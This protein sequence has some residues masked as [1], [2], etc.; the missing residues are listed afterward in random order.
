M[1]SAF[2]AELT[3]ARKR[4]AIW[5]LFATWLVLF[6]VFSFA[7]PY[8]GYLTE[9]GGTAASLVG[10]QET[11]PDQLVVNG[12]SGV[13]IF[14]GAILL[15][16][17]ALMVGSEYGWGTL[18]T[19]LTQRPTRLTV[20]WAK[21][22]A[23]V[24]AALGVILVT[25]ALGAALSAVIASIE[26]QPSSWPGLGDVL[27]GVAS[28]WLILSMWALFGA[29]LAFVFRNVALP[30][31][32][33]VVWIMGIENLISSMADSLLTALRPLRDVLPGVNSGSLV[34]SLTSD[35]QVGSASPGV[36]DAV[37]GGRAVATLGM[38]LV[39]FLVGS[40]IV[41]RRRDVT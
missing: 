39:V 1:R 30:I 27:A 40:A 31:G 18:K 4:P 28:G 6:V 32:L 33:G 17:G 29:A 23:I 9:D 14:G 26:S 37:S 5:V 38:Y 3:K 2:V 13:S 36:I 20:L 41:L 7:L 22:A 12:L 8:A 11:L 16:M 25:F 34:S 10:L 21:L 19:L 15:I 24:A 35:V